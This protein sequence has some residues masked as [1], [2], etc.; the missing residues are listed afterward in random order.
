[1]F[2]AIP[3]IALALCALLS[4]PAL[5]AANFHSISSVS[6]S[7]GGSDLWPVS[8]LIQGPGTGFEAPEPHDSLGG[9]AT[10]LWVTDN[11]NGGADYYAN[12]EPDPVLIFDLGADRQLNEISTWGYASSNTNGAKDFA[13]RFATSAEGT[14]G[15]ETSITYTPTFEADFSSTARDSNT[16]SQTVTARYV[17]MRITDNWG[18]MQG[19]TS[20]GDRVGLGEV[21]FE[22]SVP[23]ADPV[24]D[25]P[26]SLNLDLDG[27][28]QTIDI[29]VGNL[30]ATQTL[31]LGVPT[32]SGANAAA[33]SVLSSPS[34]IA[35][36]Q[37]DLIQLAF[38]PTGLSGSISAT[39]TVTSN[40]VNAPTTQVPLSGF[41]HDPRLVVAA[42]LDLG[43]F[44]SGAGVQS[45]TVDIANGGAAQTLTISS[46]SIT[47]SHAAHFMVTATPA[48]LAPLTN[49]SITIAFD[50]MGTEGAFQA[51]L[52]IGT[53]DAVTPLR[54]VTL[55]AFVGD[56]IP[57]AG[58]RINEFMASNGMTLDDGDGNSSDWIELYNAGPGPADLG[59]WHLTDSAG[60]LD[61][62][63]FPAGTILDENSYLLVF[64]SG[65]LV[66]D[67][68]DAGGFL[69][70]NFKLST[71]G[72]YLALVR[73]DGETVAS[74]LAPTFP[75]QFNDIS[76]GTFQSGGA[77]DN[78]IANSDADVLVPS[79]GSLGLTW[80]FPSFTP[81]PGA[82]WI[83]NGTGTGVGYDTGASYDALIDI[84]IESQLRNNGTSA[85]IRIPFPVTDLNSIT[86]LAFTIRY[87]D[88]F[89]A[90][91]NGDEIANRNA[92]ANPAWNSSTSSSVDENN[93]VET[94]EISQF[95]GSLQNGDNVL[96]IHG[97][98]RSASNGDF[99]MD[100]QLV[101]TTTGSGPLQLGY[102]NQPTPGAPN[103]G[104]ASN[105][106]P[107]IVEVTHS[108]GQPTDSQDIVVTAQVRP[109]QMPISAVVLQYRVQYGNVRRAGM[110][111]DGTGPDLLAG[112]GLYTG[113]IPA[114][115]YGPEDMVRWYVI[116]SDADSATSRAPA[117]LDQSGKNQSPEYFGTVTRDPTVS[118]ELPLFQWFTT[119]ESAAHTRSGTRASV[120]F[121]GRFYDNIFVRQRGGA[122]NGSV[123]QKFDFNKG[124]NLYIDDT[125][126][127]VTE[128][129]MNGRGSDSTYVR[130]PLAF[131]AYRTAG[132]ASCFSELWQMRVNGGNDRV[133]V[134]IEQVDEDFLERNGYD[135][136]GDLYKFV[137]RSNLNPVFF[138]TVTGI[139]KKTGDQGALTTVQDLVA[140]LN[141]GSSTARRNW[142]LDNLDLPQV[143]NYLAVRS[144]TQDA[145][146][147]R[148]N[149]Y[150]FMDARGDCRWRIF[151]WDKDW[152]FGVTGDGG[153]H[154]PHPFFGDE[155]HA[156][157]NANQWNVLYDVL[158]E[159]TPTQRAYLRRLRTV[160]DE[161]LQPATTPRS[162]RYF[163]ID[164][165]CRPG[166]A[167]HPGHAGQRFGRSQEHYTG[168]WHRAG[169]LVGA[170]GLGRGHR[171]GPGAGRQV[172]GEVPLPQPVR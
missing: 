119:S 29:T 53:N 118:S 8:N 78:L 157:Q 127:S 20:G 139:E 132:N 116:A 61:K 49:G 152:T 86:G 153:T 2:R 143:L 84:D 48:G 156:K 105:P 113:T 3:P 163:D 41:L 137:Q 133:G 171:A 144:I 38:D 15:F 170:G 155:E 162:E 85:Y 11:P 151:P 77:S 24:I 51:E 66:D 165:R 68:L 160:M 1:M 154:L 141:Q 55:S 64:A 50:P 27:S 158:F 87:D 36:G 19:G 120:Y 111:D 150:M 63:E 117:F 10:H 23:A 52:E 124:D 34:S 12:N 168:L 42:S 126:P 142:V 6:S 172:P 5:R 136:D 70:T 109:R 81:T 146:D 91:L 39:M 103:T 79:D 37:D 40:D 123:S 98:N 17:E 43:S 62:W 131:E 159:E 16:F 138:D 18:G 161:V 129:N 100:P 149:F 60:N 135:P 147:V 28:V 30:G 107:E 97:I 96:A 9:G 102:L 112:D 94:I 25:L 90:Y 148:K 169:V 110:A 21:A 74:E 69:H 46:T 32:M 145:D 54:T 106:G 95:L 164:D 89:Y 75:F 167:H 93:N 104:G 59:G 80:T 31:T 7:T 47:G 71:D 82:A 45:G 166:R 56:P 65:Q 140:G 72:E 13:L 73:P 128:I 99:L 101:A 33:F 92:P 76:F 58:L 67:Y 108:P 35:P 44:P 88:G 57:N 14:G 121:R 4:A 115:A 26:A 130:Q 22:D 122:T 114:G 134:F 125:M 83:T